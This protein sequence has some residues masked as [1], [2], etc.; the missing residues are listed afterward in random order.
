MSLN[1]GIIGVTGLVGKTLLDILLNDDNSGCYNFRVCASDNSIGKI[2]TSNNR[3]LKLEALRDLFFSNLDVVFFCADSET[4]KKWVSIA[5]ENDVFI[6][7]SSSAFR[8]EDDISLVIPEI[9]GHLVSESVIV[10]SPNCTTSLLCMVLYPLLELSS[11]DEV[12]VST[13]QAVSGAGQSGLDELVRQT[14]Q[15]SKNELI[16]TKTFPSQILNNCFSHN[17]TIDQKN[18][19]NEEELKMINE[20]RKILNR[21]IILR[22]TCVRVPVMTSHSESVQITFTNP[23]NEEDIRNKLLSFDGI[24]VMDDRQNNKFPEPILSSGKTDVFVGRIRKDYFDKTNKI[25]NMFICGDQL[26][27]GA[28]YNAYQIFKEFEKLKG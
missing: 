20:T 5:L 1:I 12:V 7:D 14:E 18:G 8:M 6:V 3:E 4:S 27:K 22:P 26:L 24:K 23:V 25:Y 13:Y 11:I 19:Y 15:Q 16:T 17:T 28:S 2:V 21:D 10:A 9:N